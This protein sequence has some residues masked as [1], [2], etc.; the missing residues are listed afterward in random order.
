MMKVLFNLRL[1]VFIAGIAGLFGGTLWLRMQYQQVN[2]LKQQNASLKSQLEQLNTHLRHLKN[3]AAT[4][5]AAVAEQQITQKKLEEK[6]N[7]VRKAL[8]NKLAENDCA[9]KPVPD[10]VIRLQRDALKHLVVSR[11]SAAGKFTD[12]VSGTCLRCA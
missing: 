11:F 9:D 6:N 2:S 10:D 12:A 5:S 1:F 3:H 7:A 8:Q 4:L